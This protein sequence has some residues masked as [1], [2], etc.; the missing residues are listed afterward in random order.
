MCVCVCVQIDPPV[1]AALTLC[2]GK[3]FSAVERNNIVC[4][5]GKFEGGSLVFV[6]GAFVV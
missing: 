4:D 2:I 5:S 3:I 1:S 6:I